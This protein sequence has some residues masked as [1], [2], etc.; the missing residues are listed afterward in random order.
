MVEKIAREMCR[1]IEELSA[2][3]SPRTALI[4]SPSR[5]VPTAVR[6]A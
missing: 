5:P 1:E 6:S 3:C 4:T 2:A